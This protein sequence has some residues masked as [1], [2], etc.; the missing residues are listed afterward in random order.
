MP[1]PYMLYIPYCIFHRVALKEFPS[2]NLI[3]SFG[4]V[5]KNDFYD[6]CHQKRQINILS[7][8]TALGQPRFST[9]E[10][11]HG[12]AWDCQS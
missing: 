10:N 6:I 12:P 3:G 4:M 1:S 8:L 9:S 7:L 5:R 11:R 2:Q